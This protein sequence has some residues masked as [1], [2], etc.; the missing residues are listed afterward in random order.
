MAEVSKFKE[1]DD[2]LALLTM[3]DKTGQVGASVLI[4]FA[5]ELQSFVAES[6]VTLDSFCI[7]LKTTGSDIKKDFML[8]YCPMHIPMDDIQEQTHEL[9]TAYK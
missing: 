1:S 8:F 4:G 3:L 7:E 2:I 5:E 9:L 6:L